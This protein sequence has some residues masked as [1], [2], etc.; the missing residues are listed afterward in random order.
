MSK[1]RFLIGLLLAAVFL[2]LFLRNINLRELG[3]FVRQGSLIWLLFAL[4]FN[5]FNYFL[6]AF[7]WRYFLL[8]IKKTRIGN[9]FVSTVIGFSAS[10]IFPARIG[11]VVRPY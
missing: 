1:G 8:P 5:L 11:E 9:L 10:T 2:Y 6:R 7:R 3:D 4:V